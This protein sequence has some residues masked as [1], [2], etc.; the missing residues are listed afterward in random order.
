MIFK[1]SFCQ[2]KLLAGQ[3]FLQSTGRSLGQGGVWYDLFRSLAAF[4][5]QRLGH[6]TDASKVSRLQPG[7]GVLQSVG[8][9]AEQRLWE[10]WG[11]PKIS[12]I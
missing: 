8:M 4:H 6:G 2:Q 7:R 5:L 11:G 3:Q 10:D 12:A 9:A 1:S